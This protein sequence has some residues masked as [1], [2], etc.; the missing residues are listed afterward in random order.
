MMLQRVGIE[1]FVVSNGQEALDEYKKHQGEYDLILMDM[2]MPIMGGEE[3][4]KLIREFDKKIPIVALTA[5]STIEDRQKVLDASMNE[6]LSKPIDSDKLYL[7]IKELC[8]EKISDNFNEAIILD[9]D[10]LQNFI[11]SQKL[12]KRLFIKFKEQLDSEFKDIVMRLKSNDQEVKMAIHSLKGV[13]GSLGAKA[14]SQICKKIED[15]LHLGIKS[16]DIKSLEIILNK[17]KNE[18]DILTQEE[19]QIESSSIKST[20]ECRENLIELKKLLSKSFV[21]DDV[22]FNNIYFYLEN[23]IAQERV[24]ELKKSVEDLEYDRAIRVVDSLLE[25]T[26]TL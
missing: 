10:F 18:L 3:A 1:V 22:F 12:S 21:I 17:T 8:K 2:Q 15:S 25:D 26:S 6:H 19:K 20:K 4:T 7:I 16:S 24:G 23:K 13:S 5:A 11:G 9:R 14:L